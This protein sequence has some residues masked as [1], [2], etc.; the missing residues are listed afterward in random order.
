MGGAVG[1]RDYRT[2]CFA[3]R[4]HAVRIAHRALACAPECRTGYFATLL[5]PVMHQI[6]AVPGLLALPPNILAASRALGRF[7]AL[8][9][10]RSWPD[11]EQALLG[12]LGA[13]APVAPL[14][15]LGAGLDAGDEW[16]IRADPVAFAV[17]HDDVRLSGSV[18]NLTSTEAQELR[19]LI[20]D[21]FA[22]DGLRFD[23]A[24]PDAWFARV[25]TGHDI[26][27]TSLEAALGRTLKPCLPAG[28]DAGRWRRWM[29]EIQML[30]HEHPLAERQPPVNGIWF[31]G[32]GSLADVEDKPHA[33]VHAG[34]GRLADLA[35]G[36]ASGGGDIDI[37]VLPPPGDDEALQIFGNTVLEPMLADWD[38]RRVERISLVTDGHGSGASWSATRPTLLQ[39]WF[40][41]QAVFE[42]PR[43]AHP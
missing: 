5:G 24:R 42:V 31:A 35:R 15:A 8:A 30:L 37:H 32:G 17:G 26:Q 9:R 27:T 33:N 25:P 22:D 16:I 23:Y 34:S 40:P 11:I 20:N 38:P 1:A 29:T 14:A 19:A 36:F 43:E 39:R 6:L 18:D 12:T 7:A 28:A 10:A 3:S 2:R 4:V 41:R 21:H 13:S